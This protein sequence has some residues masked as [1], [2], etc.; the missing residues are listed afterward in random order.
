MKNINIVNK[1]I[2]AKT[3]IDLKTVEQVNKSYWREVRDTLRTVKDNYVHLKKIGTISVSWYK[4]KEEI[5]RTILLIKN[6]RKSPKYTEETRTKYLN[7]YY[8][9]LRKLLE[10]RNDLAREYYNDKTN[11]HTE[12]IHK[13]DTSGDQES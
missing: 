13:A 7:Y 11:E 6:I 12:F 10:V 3:G 8:D 2:A 9:F 5:K 4:T 1:T